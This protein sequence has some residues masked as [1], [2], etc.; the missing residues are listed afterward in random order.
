MGTAIAEIPTRPRDL[1]PAAD[2]RRFGGGLARARRAGAGPRATGPGAAR[3][4][5]AFDRGA[6]YYC[7][8]EALQNAGKHGGP[9]TTVTVT[10]AG[11]QTL[12]L[13]ISDTGSSSTPRPWGWG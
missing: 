10:A 8:S 1:P 6:F 13:T 5:P 4:L 2:Q 11:E 3:P 12:T 7:C 9:A